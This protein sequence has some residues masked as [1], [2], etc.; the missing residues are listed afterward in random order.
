[1]KNLIQ[2][3]Q[4]ITIKMSGDN[5]NQTQRNEIKANAN[6]GLKELLVESGLQAVLVN[7]GVAFEI[8]SASGRKVKIVI[9]AVIKNKL[10]D[11][12]TESQAYIDTMNER[13]EKER[14]KAERKAEKLKEIGR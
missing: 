3:L 14:I 5:I 10:Y 8:K 12:E 1:M 9:D 11:L 7:G 2:E 13:A 6:Q 4:E